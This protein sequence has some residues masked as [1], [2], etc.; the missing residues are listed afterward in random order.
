MFLIWQ[1]PHPLYLVELL[2]RR[3]SEDTRQALVTRSA[4][5]V[6]ETA[7]FMADFV[8]ERDRVFHLPAPP[9]PA[10][11]FYDA[12]STE[13]PTFELAYWW[14]GLEIAQRRRE[15]AGR[16]RD[17]QWQR[18]QDGLPHCQRDGPYT[19]IAPKPYLRR[20]DH[21]ALLCASASCRTLRSSTRPS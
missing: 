17:K 6:E 9:V 10:Q 14:W 15:R 3:Q 4:E 12:A 11:E 20:D 13:A 21:P 8:E 7:A 16:E 18:V 19:A 1:Q 5:L 2:H